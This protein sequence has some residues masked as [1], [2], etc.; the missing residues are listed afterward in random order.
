MAPASVF[1]P[2]LALDYVRELSTDVRAGIVLDAA[3]ERLAGPETLVEAAR[4]LL[5]AAGLAA[6]LEAATADGVVCAARSA[7]HALIVVCGPY[8]LPALVR[9][10]LRTALGALTGEGAG[11]PA[12]PARRRAHPAMRGWSGPP[13][14][15]FP[16]SSADFRPDGASARRRRAEKSPQNADVSPDSAC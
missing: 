14:R 1:S 11:E 2:A 5:A 15:S 12:E 9:R 4:E 16:R 10:D 6:E 3:G 7:R 13:R 8:A